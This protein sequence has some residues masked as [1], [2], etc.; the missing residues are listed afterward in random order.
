MRSEIGECGENG[1]KTPKSDGDGALARLLALAPQ[2]ATEWERVTHNRHNLLLEGPA[3][4]T[5]TALSLLEPYFVKPVLLKRPGEPLVLRAGCTL[6]LQE[7]AALSADEQACLRRHLESSR[8]VP[9][10][11][12]TASRRLFAAVER[13]LFDEVLYYRLNVM[14]LRL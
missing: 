11:V 5:E 2:F 14:L 10:V 3:R 6:I 13:G 8:P 7:A 12:S 1:Q 9:R 4:A